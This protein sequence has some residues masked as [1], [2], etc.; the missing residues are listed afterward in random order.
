MGNACA[1]FAQSLSYYYFAQKIYQIP[2]KF[3]KNNLFIIAAFIMVGLFN[4]FIAQVGII[5]STVY[6]IIFQF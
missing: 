5:M 6:G 2:Y 3:L 1:A 4:I